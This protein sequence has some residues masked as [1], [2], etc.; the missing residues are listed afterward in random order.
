MIQAY[1][2][3]L[4]QHISL[5][6][7]CRAE[8]RRHWPAPHYHKT[9]ND[10]FEE[11][12]E[13]LWRQC[14][15][16]TS[17][18]SSTTA[19]IGAHYESKTSR[20]AGMF[21]PYETFSLHL[22]RKR[23]KQAI[24][25]S[26]RH[27]KDLSLEEQQQT[28][29]ET[30][31]SKATRQISSSNLSV[32]STSSARVSDAIPST[33]RTS[34][35]TRSGNLG[36]ASAITA[37]PAAAVDA[38]GKRAT[39]STSA[40]S[41]A[42]A[43]VKKTKGTSAPTARP[44]ASAS[45]PAKA[46]TTTVVAA[47]PPPPSPDPLASVSSQKRSSG[48]AAAAAKKESAAAPV[49]AAEDSGYAIPKRNTRKPK[50]A[51][52]DASDTKPKRAGS[53]STAPVSPRVNATTTS[54]SPRSEVATKKKKTAGSS[55]SRVGSV[56]AN[57]D[58][59]SERR[60]YVRDPLH[61]RLPH[62]SPYRGRQATGRSGHH[63]VH[64]TVRWSGARQRWHRFLAQYPAFARLER[65][66]L[67]Q[68]PIRRAAPS[69]SSDAHEMGLNVVACEDDS[70]RR[71]VEI[72]PRQCFTSPRESESVEGSDAARSTGRSAAHPH[73][74]VGNTSSDNAPHADVPLHLMQQLCS[75]DREANQ[76]TTTAAAERRASSSTASRPTAP[77][78]HARMHGLS[79]DEEIVSCAVAHSSV[80]NSSSGNVLAPR[81]SGRNLTL[82]SSTILSQST[83]TAA[84]TSA[85]GISGS[86]LPT[87]SSIEHF[88][89]ISHSAVRQPNSILIIRSPPQDYVDEAAAC[90]SYYHSRQLGVAENANN[91]LRVMGPVNAH[92]ICGLPGGVA[93]AHSQS[94][95]RV[96]Y[97]TANTHSSTHA[98]S[99]QHQSLKLSTDRGSNLSTSQSVIS[100]P[101]CA[102]PS[103]QLPQQHSGLRG[104][105][106]GQ[107]LYSL[108][109]SGRNF[110]DPMASG[111]VLSNLNSPTHVNAATKTRGGVGDGGRAA[112]AGGVIPTLQ[113]PLPSF[114]STPLFPTSPFSPAV[115]APMLLMRSV[116]RC[117]PT[118]T[119]AGGGQE[120]PPPLSVK[121]VMTQRGRSF[122]LRQQHQQ[123]GSSH[124]PPG[125][126][127]PV[128]VEY[129]TEIPPHPSHEDPLPLTAD[130]VAF[131]P[132]AVHMASNLY[133]D[134]KPPNWKL[135]QALLSLAPPPPPP[136]ASRPLDAAPGAPQLLGNQQ[137]TSAQHL[138]S[139]GEGA[140]HTPRIPAQI[141]WQSSH[142]SVNSVVPSGTGES[143]QLL[144]Q[145]T[146]PS[147]IEVTPTTLCSDEWYLHPLMG[148]EGGANHSSA[149]Y[150]SH[151]SVSQ[152]T[153]QYGDSSTSFMRCGSDSNLPET[154]LCPLAY[155]QARLY[156]TS[157]STAWR[158]NTS[159]ATVAATPVLSTMLAHGTPTG[160]CVNYL[161]NCYSPLFLEPQTSLYRSHQHNFTS[162]VR[163]HQ[164]VSSCSLASTSFLSHPLVRTPSLCTMGSASLQGARLASPGLART[165]PFA[166]TMVT[167]TASAPQVFCKY[168]R[169][170]HQRRRHRLLPPLP[171]MRCPGMAGR[172]AFDAY[173]AAVHSGV[174]TE[175]E[176]CS[177]YLSHRRCTSARATPVA[178]L[179]NLY[180]QSAAVTPAPG[181]PLCV[182]SLADCHI[183]SPL[184]VTP[185]STTDDGHNARARWDDEQEESSEVAVERE[186]TTSDTLHCIYHIP[187]C[188]DDL[189]HR[190]EEALEMLSITTT[191]SCAFGA[192]LDGLCWKDWMPSSPVDAGEDMLRAMEQATSTAA[193]SPASSYAR[194]SSRLSAIVHSSS[195]RSQD[196]LSS[197]PLASLPTPSATPAADS[198]SAAS[199]TIAGAG[200]QNSTIAASSRQASSVFGNG[201]RVAPRNSDDLVCATCRALD[202]ALTEGVSM[203]DAYLLA[204]SPAYC[205][206]GDNPPLQRHHRRQ[207]SST[208]MSSDCENH[209]SAPGSGK[210]AF[211][212]E[213]IVSKL[214]KHMEKKKQK[215]Q[216]K[217]LEFEAATTTSKG[218]AAADTTTSKGGAAAGVGSTRKPRL[219]AGL[220]LL[221]S[222]T[223][224]LRGHSG[225]S[226]MSELSDI[227]S[228]CGGNSGQ[229]SKGSASRRQR[230]AYLVTA[231]QTERVIH[232][233]KRREV[234]ANHR[235]LEALVHRSRMKMTPAA[236]AAGYYYEAHVVTSPS[237]TQPLAQSHSKPFVKAPLKP[238]TTSAA[239]V[240]KKA[241]AI[242]D[243]A[244][245]CS[246]KCASR[247]GEHIE[248]PAMEKHPSVSSQSLRVAAQGEAPSLRHTSKAEKGLANTMNPQ[249]KGSASSSRA[250]TTSVASSST[251]TKR[252]LSDAAAPP[253]TKQQSEGGRRASKAP[254]TAS[255]AEAERMRVAL[256]TLKT[257]KNAI[258]T[259][260]RGLQR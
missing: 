190:D 174:I 33:P 208:G 230:L 213:W 49:S 185:L 14:T 128:G 102:T 1:L 148:D 36:G 157:E 203:D 78:S 147:H 79:E 50:S 218:G 138:T 32:K 192:G 257:K 3:D 152:V 187:R 159:I 21:N 13:L 214:Q 101:S 168:Q 112:H 22:K 242:G 177:Y 206:G 99:T 226:S 201:G 23:K 175:E 29:T 123:E 17:V 142:F 74:T 229:L 54:G 31:L 103:L 253:L 132:L 86:E 231:Y 155:T 69:G 107:P 166:N 65:A 60:N 211:I 248:D 197:G 227:C 204:T 215:M 90:G 221:S 126:C 85:L 198:F 179:I 140:D 24:A 93:S 139:G 71:V 16:A 20:S 188:C 247:T 38:K 240:A 246:N 134:S 249:R 252:K 28:T 8:L 254:A 80:I 27:F 135:A 194:D 199:P 42:T 100:V 153:Q 251:A 95:L 209:R 241:D 41:E 18:P 63:P 127:A 6:P 224:A 228:P 161:C 250:Q 40:A 259:W 73:R 45:S 156:S 76:T 130:T 104:V 237:I 51:G 5:H 178:S 70:Y 59:G 133:K 196:P 146:H 217:A 15:E 68:L 193:G 4:A 19:V 34:P 44:S 67:L 160:S 115:T 91:L 239:T 94:R 236:A 232:E 212:A 186:E 106:Y 37:N 150:C 243:G 154:S 216:R 30:S 162:L 245:R 200:A 172:L 87:P 165:S 184:G 124:A 39:L 137:A 75:S 122:L 84:R 114:P 83:P 149:T 64:V 111:H 151:A 223:G 170:D 207:H 167:S 25:G 56:A 88:P 2:S 158:E 62:N 125:D 260:I 191:S 235:E 108:N 55:S 53:S 189:Y 131:T 72:V 202:P 66:M 163:S 145:R 258:K 164:R 183:R 77:H 35:R 113:S 143:F 110:S 47:P 176:E 98:L 61:I 82:K 169:S 238:A 92:G 225:T 173:R 26:Q 120:K 171:G 119:S 12:E 136:R 233:Q 7:S 220:N 219:D 109:A 222:P 234:E 205:D 116:K 57:S 97:V 52:C 10:V 105:D 121:R 244:T 46:A 96:T 89:P 182:V 48:A 43:A 81:L 118:S 11:A 255:T 117:S 141:H 58:S 129:G 180:R 144:Q 210:R 256:D 9:P 195:R 181:S